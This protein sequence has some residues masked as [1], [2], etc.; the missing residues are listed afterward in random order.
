MVAGRVQALVGHSILVRERA[1]VGVSSVF[2]SSYS[3]EQ[4]NISLTSISKREIV[5]SQSIIARCSDT[6]ELNIVF[7]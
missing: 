1:G 5:T 7:D 4:Q 2:V 6:L 3:H